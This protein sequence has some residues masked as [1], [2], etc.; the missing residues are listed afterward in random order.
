MV[1]ADELIAVGMQGTKRGRPA[2][3]AAGDRTPRGVDV[4]PVR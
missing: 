2:N 4:E 3:E 1:A